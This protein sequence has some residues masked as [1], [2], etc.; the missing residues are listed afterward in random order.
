MGSLKKM[1]VEKLP[2]ERQPQVR[3]IVRYLYCLIMEAFNS[4][5][6]KD[7]DGKGIK[8]FQ[9]VLLSIGFPRTAEMIFN[10]WME[11][12]K[13]AAEAVPVADDK[14]GGKDDK[15]KAKE[16]EKKKG[17]DDK[18]DKKESKDDKKDAKGK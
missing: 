10:Q 1:Q 8:L 11:A 14:K 9:E 3:Q 2:A 16:D 15:K 17:K 4:Y 5:G 7:I 6:K 18:K 13:P 12:H